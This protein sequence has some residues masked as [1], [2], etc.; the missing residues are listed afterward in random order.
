M[1]NQVT[2]ISQKT[3]MVESA[4]KES[5]VHDEW[6]NQYLCTE[7]DSFFGDS[8]QW[9]TKLTATSKHCAEGKAVGSPRPQKYSPFSL[10]K[11][12]CPPTS[13]CCGIAPLE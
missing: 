3:S 9:A 8:Y 12:I 4:L 11:S 7:N 2:D 13:I 10:L 5:T 6:K 1:H